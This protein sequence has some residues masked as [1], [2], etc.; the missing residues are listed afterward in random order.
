MDF[1]KQTFSQIADLF[2]SM[3][4]GSRITAAL[5]LVVVVVSVAYLFTVQ[6]SGPDVD[7]MGGEPFPA[8]RLPAMEAAFAKAGLSSYEVDG[9]RIRIPRGQQA[10]Y[11]GALADG[12]ALPPSFHSYLDDALK[13]DSPFTTRRQQEERRKNAREKELALIISSIPWV[14][15]A[16]V[17]Y[18]IET[19]SGFKREKITTAAATVWPK[20]AEQLDNARVAGIRHLLAAAIP[21]LGADAVTVVNGVTGLARH[22]GDAENSGGSG[23]SVLADLQERYERRWK[24]KILGA[25]GYVP[26]VVVTANVVLDP[27]RISRSIKRTI[28]P[29]AV[30]IRGKDRSFTHSREGGGTAEAPGFWANVANRAQALANTTAAGSKESEDTSKR[31]V[32]IIPSGEETE[33]ETTGHTPTRVTAS[34]SI[35]NSYFENIGRKLHPT[36]EGEEPATPEKAQ[37]DQIRAEETAKIAKHVANI[38][39]PAE[40]VS[41]PLELVNVSVFPDL[42]AEKPPAPSLGGGALVWLGQYWSTLAMVGLALFSLVMLRSM[43][44]AAPTGPGQPEALRI[45]PMDTNEADAAAAAA[46]ARASRLGRFTGSGPSLRD[47]L[48][49]LVREDPDAAANILRT[50][51]GNVG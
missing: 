44:R 49:D 25:L 42:P 33:K 4:P 15:S 31:N 27:Q 5:L 18:A 40:G 1:L 32:A 7:L 51:I 10:A 14:E 3:T 43:V 48:S 24:N 8:S 45:V 20:G 41:D 2:R 12:K 22:A 6:V 35:P 38:L 11:I 9:N 28:N 29:K 26:G 23:A 39:P 19:K 36:K 30:A 47:E 37:L 34:V 21:G 50:W 16:A 46:A 17:L 13:T